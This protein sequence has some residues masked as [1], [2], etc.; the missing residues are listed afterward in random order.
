MTVSHG[1]FAEAY[2]SWLSSVAQCCAPLASCL[3]QKPR[4]SKSSFTTISWP[5]GRTSDQELLIDQDDEKH[6]HAPSVASHAVV[7]EQP[8]F[9]A[10]PA[11]VPGDETASHSAT[12]RERLPRKSFG[13]S[14]TSFSVRKR[15]KSDASSRRPQISAPS[16]FQHLNS[17]SFDFPPA[18][19]MPPQPRLNRPARRSSFRPLELSMYASDNSM[20]P[21][22]PHFEFPDISPPP[23]AYVANRTEDD[24]H[25]HQRSYSAMS[26]HLPRNGTESSP[27]T[28]QEE[29]PPQIPPKAKAR[30]RA[31]TSPNVDHLKERVASAMIEVE[32]L[33]KQID[34]VVER[35]SLYVASRPSTPL[36]MA[37]TM[38]GKLVPPCI[39]PSMLTDTELEPMPSIPAL[40]PA[41]PSF[42]ERLNS[43]MERPR[44]APLRSPLR[45][46]NRSKTFDEAS[47]AFD[48]PSPVSLDDRAPPPPLPLVLRPP[49][50][51]KKSFSRVSTW[52]FPAP[53]HTRNVSLETI[54]NAPRPVK[55]SEGFYQCVEPG[56][57]SGRR[58]VES[59]DT[60]S[61]WETDGERTVPTTWSPESTPVTKQE[62]STIERTTTFGKTSGG[63]VGRTSVGVAF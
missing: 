7:Y 18:E 30:A 11:A 57:G 8:A 13:S 33:Q 20:S 45:I 4:R 32:R 50:R 48:G 31:Y 14:R 3:D 59:V 29:M 58:S 17:G 51:K 35:Q 56:E 47:S 63:R 36:S 6:A 42:A 25:V 2:A 15:F 27:S 16:D 60:V 9:Q 10:L 22:L 37:R 41:A 19:P 21:I 55:G 46:P 44:T 61:T 12:W 28:S 39:Y 53:D 26:F 54:T 49:L 62:E 24:H 43:D 38:P 23:P 5:L 1:I 52:L 34:D 40:P